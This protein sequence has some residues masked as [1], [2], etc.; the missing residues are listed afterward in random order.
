MLP[1]H[2][3]CFSCHYGLKRYFIMLTLCCVKMQQN[4][5]CSETFFKTPGYPC[6]C[7][8]HCRN[9]YR[10][11]EGNLTRNPTILFSVFYKLCKF[12][13]KFPL[14]VTNYQDI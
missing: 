7:H 14:P 13:I 12:Y 6:S 8:C 4:N 9:Y 2:I 3:I 10:F 11:I 1:Y 5:S